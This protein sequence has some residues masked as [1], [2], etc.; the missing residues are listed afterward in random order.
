M[1]KLILV[2]LAICNSFWLHSQ[3]QEWE[4]KTFTFGSASDP[5][6]SW[7]VSYP[8]GNLVKEYEVSSSKLHFYNSEVSNDG[9]AYCRYFGFFT[10]MKVPKCEI[11]F[12]IQCK[13]D[14][15]KYSYKTT[16]QNGKPFQYNSKKKQNIYWGL[17]I[18]GKKYE[19]EFAQLANRHNDYPYSFT[20]YRTS[21]KGWTCIEDKSLRNFI[22][23]Y[24]GKSTIH[25]YMDGTL[26][27]TMNDAVGF[28][29]VRFMIGSAADLEITNIRFKH[30]TNYGIA[31]PEID[32]AINE[33]NQG[34]FSTT[35]SII[36]NLLNNYKAAYP[37]YIR[38]RAYSSN[39]LNKAA[40]DDYCS[41]LAYS[42]DAE[43]RRNIY[44]NRGICRLL[45]DDY[46]N[47]VADMRNAGEEGKAFLKEYNLENYQPGQR[48]AASGVS[49]N[50]SSGSSST[51]QLRKGNSSSNSQ[52]S[53]P[54]LRKTN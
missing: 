40:I 27:K 53:T 12:T 44:F 29:S 50:N 42:C 19:I 31:K 35:I 17:Q 18:C 38:G 16:M 39:K 20:S 2:L 8:G 13:S 1:K 43:L 15:S 30:I 26:L 9:N 51:P 37:Y 36:S 4:F 48:K 23:K 3:E 52:N 34:N 33:F 46:D 22:I 21:D 41:A 14:P 49:R 28:G 32:R 54:A 6:K 45:L 47:G 5:D 7:C 24:D 11:S 25:L 10:T